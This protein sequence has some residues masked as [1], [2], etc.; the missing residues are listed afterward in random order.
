M[1]ELLDVDDILSRNSQI[2]HKE[3]ERFREAA[4]QLRDLGVK[5]KEYDLAPPFG[6]RRVVVRD[7]PRTDTRIVRLRR[8]HVTR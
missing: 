6:G 2:D 7:D 3:L 8:F 1:H 4:R 5:P